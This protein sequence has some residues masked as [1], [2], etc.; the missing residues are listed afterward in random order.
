ME[1]LSEEPLNEGTDRKYCTFKREDLRKLLSEVA[2]M[3]PAVFITRLAKIELRDAVVIR[4]QDYFASPA[5]ATYASCIGIT[6]AL[7]TD[8]VTK[9]RLRRIS[10]YFQRQSELAA[11]E[12]WKLPD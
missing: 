8:Q 3:D 7:S 4:R 1:P 10:D 6:S 11:E 2:G 12:G 9:V 5:L